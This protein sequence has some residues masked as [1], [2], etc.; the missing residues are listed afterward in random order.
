MSEHRKPTDEEWPIL[1]ELRL[2]YYDHREKG[3][4]RP[5]DPGWHVCRCGW[6]GYWSDYDPHVAQRVAA[7]LDLTREEG[8]VWTDPDDGTQVPWGTN[9]PPSARPMVRFVTR[10]RPR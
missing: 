3:S 4:E 1:Q 2:H 10:W 8:R 5:S 7:A 9:P 6:Q